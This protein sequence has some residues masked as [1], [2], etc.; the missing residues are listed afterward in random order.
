MSQSNISQL[1]KFPNIFV[2]GLSGSGKDT[3]TNYVKDNYGYIPFR[4]AETIKRIIT[5]KRGITFD[6]LEVL[7][8]K[9]P[10]IRK[11]HNDVSTELT[12]NAF[13]TRMQQIVDRTCMEFQ[14]LPEF[15]KN[16]P[17]IVRDVR[18]K[19]EI[20]FF[21]QNG[22][23]GIFLERRTGEY[24]QKEHYTEWDVISSG[25]ID[26]YRKQFFGQCIT[27]DNT[28]WS[29]EGLETAISQILISLAK[30]K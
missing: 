13:Y 4:L 21:L 6:E 2:C 5:E 3:V 11:E 25:A 7:K 1:K 18:A 9:F 20:E 24:Q 22:Y 16:N 29:K 19:H 26:E 14:I 12:L 8:R 10:E 28:S 27:L 17:I 15:W 30:N 23:I